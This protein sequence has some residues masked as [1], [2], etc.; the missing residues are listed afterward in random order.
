MATRPSSVPPGLLGKAALCST[1]FVVAVAL[2]V[3]GGSSPGTARGDVAAQRASVGHLQHDF[4][5]D[6]KQTPLLSPG[7][8]ARL[9]LTFKKKARY[10]YLCT[11]PGHAVA[12]MKGVFTVR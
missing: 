7:R 5:I 12:G 1:P 4:R 9:A 8:T 11:V 6:G 3:W 2:A 10:T